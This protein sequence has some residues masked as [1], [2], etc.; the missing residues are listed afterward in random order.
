M[1]AMKI[2]THQ[3]FWNLN[4]VEYPW[5]TP[6]AGVIYRTFAPAELAPQLKAAGIDKTV[7]V[8]SANNTEDTISMLT[9]SEDY[10]WI[11]AVVGWV[12]LLRPDQT[13][14]YLQRYS[15]HPKFRGMRHLIHN[16]ADPDWIIQDGVIEGLKV[17]AEFNMVFE[18]VAV[19]PNH[20]KHAP[21]L[22]ERLPNLTIVIDHLAKPP[23]KDK[24]MGDWAAQMAAAASFPNVYAK[25][26]GLNTAAD[27]ATW[28]AADLKP[29]IDFV[30]EKFGADR[31]MFGSDWPVC[32]LAG[33]YARVWAETNTALAG[34]SQ[35]EIDAILGG[36]AQRVYRV[37]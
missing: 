14:V 1:S 35:G 21:L 23:I 16:E 8:Q 37:S 15:G 30:I 3:H 33:D 20:L 18:F 36:T 25:V 2:D 10:D 4:K 29:Y 17:L 26:S 34:Q 5:L 22:C 11:G 31:L 19:Y 9:Q 7:L 13:R 28:S 27:Y 32:T 12:P 24:Q 6:S